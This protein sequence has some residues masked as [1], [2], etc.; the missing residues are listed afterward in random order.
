QLRAEL[1]RFWPGA[2]EIFSDL[3]SPISLL[4]L[5]RYPS[6][7]DARGLGEK[8]LAAFLARHGYCGRKQPSQLLAKLRNAPEGCAAEHEIEVRRQIVLALIAALRPIVHKITELTAEIAHR[9]RA[10]PDG[11]IFL[12]LF[13]DPKSVVTAAALLAEIGD[14]RDRYPTAGALAA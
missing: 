6:P 4:F 9:V 14:C 11:E 13:K 12:S 2:I 1:E 7:L 5:E 8:R 3:D 10:H